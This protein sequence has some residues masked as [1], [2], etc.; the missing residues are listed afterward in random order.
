[1]KHLLFKAIPCNLLLW[2]CESWALRKSLLASL[3]VF[4]HRGIRRILKI[5]MSEVIEQHITNTSIRKKFFNIPTIKK[6]ITLRQLTYL[7]KIFCR[8]ESHIPTRLLTVWCD[9][10]RKAGRAILTNKQSMVRNIQQVIPNVDTHGTMSTWVFHA[11][12]T[13]HRNE[14]LNTLRHS[15]FNPPEND[16]IKQQEDNVPPPKQT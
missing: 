4:L 14:L 10:Q 15:S 13:Q 1:M 5:R 9:H 2:G 16:P 11:L 6:Q 8:E 12:D 3:V 7:G